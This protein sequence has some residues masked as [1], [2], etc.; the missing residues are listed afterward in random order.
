[1]QREKVRDSLYRHFGV[2]SRRHDDA[3]I[4]A[5]DDPLRARFAALNFWIKIGPS[6]CDALIHE[7][8]WQDKGA[9]MS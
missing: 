1:M 4:T 8:N 9:R 6:I 5:L 7:W 3:D 2:I